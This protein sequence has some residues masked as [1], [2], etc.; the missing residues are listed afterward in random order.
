M[1]SEWARACTVWILMGTAVLAAR[2]FGSQAPHA[3]PGSV[4]PAGGEPVVHIDEQ[5]RVIVEDAVNQYRF[6]IPGAYW[7]YKT[8]SQV[9]SQ[10]AGGGPGC[11]G[12]QPAVTSSLLLG[13]NNKD[14]RG[15]ASLERL[16]QRFLM[17]GKDDLRAFVDARLEALR[18]RAGGAV[19]APLSEFEERDGMIVHRAVF[20]ASAESQGQQFILVNY[21]VRP[22]GEDAYMYQLACMAMA[23]DYGELEED[24]EH[25]IAGFRFTGEVAEAF[26][27]PNAPPEKLPSAELPAAPRSP[28]GGGASGMLFAAV[29]VFLIYS[30][31]KRRA[32]ARA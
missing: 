21:F 29:F 2:A 22:K 24:F 28:C 3:G 16:P 6:S 8:A 26:F 31:L 10:A 4:E 9:A 18:Q 23:E 14:A 30:L 32:A 17:R 11:A 13:V 19:D 25:M 27:D 15:M 12:R 1:R 20:S 7:E 5:G